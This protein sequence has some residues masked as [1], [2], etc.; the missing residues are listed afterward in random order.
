MRKKTQSVCKTRWTDYKRNLTFTFEQRGISSMGALVTLVGISVAVLVWVGGVEGA[1]P[2]QTGWILLSAASLNVR[3]ST[4]S[5]SIFSS[6]SISTLWCD[7]LWSVS[8]FRLQNGL[9]KKTTPLSKTEKKVN[10]Y[11][12][13]V[14]E[15]FA[16]DHK[17]IICIFA[18]FSLTISEQEEIILLSFY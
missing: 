17:N 8:K 14:E 6:L 16:T 10:S 15:H 9:P 2:Y 12:C 3:I 18:F 11:V 7:I 1:H 13:R 4:L 5:C